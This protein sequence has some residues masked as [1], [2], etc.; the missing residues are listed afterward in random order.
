MRLILGL[1][2][3]LPNTAILGEMVWTPWKVSQR[4]CIARQFCHYSKIEDRHLNKYVLKWA[5]NSRSRNWT[6]KCKTLFEEFHFND[7]FNVYVPKSKYKV[8]RDFK[9]VY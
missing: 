3:K 5:V 9:I 1:Q 7:L 4:K 6:G 8:A 2:C